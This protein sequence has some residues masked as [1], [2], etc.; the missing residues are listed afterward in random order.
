MFIL[1]FVIG[2][3]TTL[4]FVFVLSLFRTIAIG[5]RLLENIHDESKRPGHVSALD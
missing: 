4:L 2:V 5:N 3:S 1:G